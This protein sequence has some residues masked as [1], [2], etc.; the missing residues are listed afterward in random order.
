M[1]KLNLFDLD[2]K[3][4]LNKASI[5]RA[6]IFILINYILPVVF[7]EFVE[8]WKNCFSLPSLVVDTGVKN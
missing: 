2:I 3:S 8:Y 5:D 6:Y 4:A 7:A 1:I